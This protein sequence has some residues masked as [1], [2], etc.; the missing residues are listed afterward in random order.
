MRV[1]DSPAASRLGLLGP[2]L[3]AVAPSALA[4]L[5]AHTRQPL[6]TWPF[7]QVP[8]YGRRADVFSFE[9]GPGCGSR[10]GVFYVAS[11]DA[12]ALFDAVNA[13]AARAEP[14]TRLSPAVLAV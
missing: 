5:D 4:L 7:P 11:A 6:C 9:A 3:L 13:L 1:L 14:M 8:H 12:R 2:A 10:Q